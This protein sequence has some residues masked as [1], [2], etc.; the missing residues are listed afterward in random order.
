M[1]DLKLSDLVKKDLLAH[2]E[3][4]RDKKLYYSIFTNN[5]KYRIS[6]PVEDSGS[7]NFNPIMKTVELMRWIRKSIESEDVYIEKI[8]SEPIE[9]TKCKNCGCHDNYEEDYCIYCGKEME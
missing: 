1:I 4:Y 6:I 8:N 7:G 2:F 9:G 5:N 3:F